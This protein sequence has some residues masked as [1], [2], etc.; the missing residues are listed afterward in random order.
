VLI[1]VG[2]EFL[3]WNVETLQVPFVQQCLYGP[4]ST[5]KKKIKMSNVY[6]TLTDGHGLVLK[7]ISSL[8]VSCP[9]LGLSVFPQEGDGHQ[10]IFNLK[11]VNSQLR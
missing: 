5:E 4:V 11:V 3:Q 9:K 1:F 10:D 2:I 7:G 8:L 6:L